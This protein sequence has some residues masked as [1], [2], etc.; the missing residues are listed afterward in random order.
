MSFTFY[1]VRAPNESPSLY[2]V[3]ADQVFKSSC[4][5][6]WGPGHA[7][8]FSS[9]GCRAGG[10]SRVSRWRPSDVLMQIEVWN[11]ESGLIFVFMI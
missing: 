9:W 2:A 8:M 4:P 10:G 1:H 6:A 5:V 3:P 11:A 7:H